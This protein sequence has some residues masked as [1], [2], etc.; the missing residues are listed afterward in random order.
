MWI[1]R[2]L[3][4]E[5]NHISSVGR[6]SRIGG[7]SDKPKC[8]LEIAGTSILENALTCLSK[9]GFQEVIL[10][11]GYQAELVRQFGDNFRKMKLIYINNP[12]YK[13]TN[14]MY[15]LYLA[16]QYLYQGFVFLNGDIFFEQRVLQRLLKGAE[17]CWAADNFKEFDGAMLNAA[18]TARITQVE[19]I[20]EISTFPGRYKSAGMIKISSELGTKLA[21]WLSEDVEKGYTHIYHDPCLPGD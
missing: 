4:D 17:D 12:D 5:G 20:R 21:S 1:R 18:D 16:R 19:T 6:G 14:T 13:T 15:S 2:L 9:E 7:I 11:V 3:V 10:V 8:L